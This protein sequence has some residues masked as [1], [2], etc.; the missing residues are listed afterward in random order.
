[1]SHMITK[2][3]CV[4][5]TWLQPC[6][7][8]N[9]EKLYCPVLKRRRVDADVDA[10]LDRPLNDSLEDGMGPPS[11]LNEAVT[12]ELCGF[13]YT[14]RWRNLSDSARRILSDFCGDQSMS[15]TVDKL[16]LQ[17]VSGAVRTEMSL[18]LQPSVPITELNRYHLINYCYKVLGIDS[19]RYPF[20]HFKFR[21]GIRL[22]SNQ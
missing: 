12:P 20:I 2:K 10:A 21:Y 1:M 5:G 13:A 9:H 6:S 3:K 14:D 15:T 22:S 7:M 16:R 19:S 17:D 4:C 18:V 11:I 8:S